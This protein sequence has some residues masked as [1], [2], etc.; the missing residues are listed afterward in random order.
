[1]YT[2]MQVN[3]HT[4]IIYIYYYTYTHTHTH[5]H[6]HIYIYIYAHKHTHTHIYI[7]TLTFAHLIKNGRNNIQSFEY[8]STKSKLF[9][10][11]QG[12]HA[13]IMHTQIETPIRSSRA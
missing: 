6:T 8:K 4:H 11:V 3:L 12:M 7:R 2:Y 1:M 13:Y 10:T 9:F 5:T